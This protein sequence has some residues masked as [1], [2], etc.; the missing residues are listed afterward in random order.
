MLKRIAQAA[1]PFS[2]RDNLADGDAD[3]LMAPLLQA[4]TVDLKEQDVA[5]QA[6]VRALRKSEACASLRPICQDIDTFERLRGERLSLPLANDIFL[7]P[8]GFVGAT[9]RLPRHCQTPH[10]RLRPPLC[11]EPL[12]AGHFRGEATPE[13]LVDYVGK[14]VQHLSR[15]GQQQIGA[16]LV[17]YDAL[18]RPDTAWHNG[19]STLQFAA[20]TAQQHVNQRVQTCAHSSLRSLKNTGLVAVSDTCGEQGVVMRCPI[21][22][23]FGRCRIPALC[24]LTL[25][26]PLIF[27]LLGLFSCMTHTE[28]TYWNEPVQGWYT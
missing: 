1:S 2:S 18:L 12:H 5:R 7:T 11:L 22:E 13:Q 21:D 25:L 24:G 28:A 16:E 6:A 10:E 23:E 17:F 26:A 15:L 4:M 19:L 3:P 14:Q 8:A 20:S 9:V 27:P